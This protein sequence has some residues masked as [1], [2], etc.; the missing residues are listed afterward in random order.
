M[1]RNSLFTLL[2][3]LLVALLAAG[4]ASASSALVLAD[5]TPPTTLDP[6]ADNSDSTCSILANVFDGL[7]AREGKEGKLIP[8]LAEKFE[9]LDLLTWK[10]YLR[11][12][13]KFHNGNPFTAADVKFT[14]ERLSDPKLS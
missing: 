1:R 4:H 8:G 6:A 13:V 14:F 10:F 12:G 11:K 5:E 9:R 7:M 2:G 3:L